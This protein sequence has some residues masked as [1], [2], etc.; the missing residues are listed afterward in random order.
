MLLALFQGL[1]QLPA[2]PRLQHTAALTVGNYAEWLAAA[3][4]GGKLHDLVPQLLQMLTS[5]ALPACF[6][7]S[8]LPF[9][10]N[11]RHAVGD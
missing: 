6:L 4:K 1:P 11:S 7:L 2:V 8:L 10:S 5:G 3:L 9:R